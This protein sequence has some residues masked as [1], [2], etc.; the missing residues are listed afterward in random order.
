MPE[1]H[2]LYPICTLFSPVK[3]GPERAMLS[4]KRVDKLHLDI[5]GA[6]LDSEKKTPHQILL[7]KRNLII[8][9]RWA[10]NH[11]HTHTH[12]HSQ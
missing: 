1:M 6:F 7:Y 4:F 2:R 8:K 5:N 12:T 11:P 10:M 3:N 9:L